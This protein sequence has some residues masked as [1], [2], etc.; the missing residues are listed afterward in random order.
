MSVYVYVLCMYVPMCI[1]VHTYHRVYMKVRGALGVG[2]CPVHCL[3]QGPF[4]VYSY[5]YQTIWSWASRGSPVSISYPLVGVPALEMSAME[6]ALYRFWR[7]EVRSSHLWQVLCPW[8]HLPSLLYILW[9]TYKSLRRILS[10]R[11]KHSKI[12]Y[13]TRVL[14]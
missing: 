3:R 14:I 7:S 2:Q 9:H 10:G 5:I 12:V 13:V 11:K 8:G 1:C 6:F 4:V